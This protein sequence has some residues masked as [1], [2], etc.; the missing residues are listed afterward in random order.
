MSGNAAG[1]RSELTGDGIAKALG[2][3]AS[4]VWT[5]LAFYIVWLLRTSLSSAVNRLTGVEGW[6]VK[7][8]LSG[9]EQAM[10]AAFE[11]AN[12]NPRWIAD[13]SQQERKEAIEKAEARRKVYEGAEILWVDDRPSNN[14]NEARMLR[15]FGALITFACTTEEALSAFKDA[16]AEAR[17]F[18]II[19]SD[20]SRDMP[21][22]PDTRAGLDM[23]AKFRSQGITLPVI[24]Y[25]GVP[26]PEA[27]IPESA[28]GVTCRP[29]F[30]L[31]LVGEALVHRFPGST[32]ITRLH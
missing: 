1:G 26:K 22:P 28:C 32:H 2:G 10:D 17:P 19:L 8:A 24:F 7:F 3:I 5:L 23:L 13:I 12:K 15:S 11:I 20:I 31:T 30:L 14:R 9:G 21:P 27:G 6:G 16:H 29:D 4:L 25:V 18:D